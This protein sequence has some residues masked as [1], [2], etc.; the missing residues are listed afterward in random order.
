MAELPAGK[1][2]LAAALDSGLVALAAE[3]G[4]ATEYWDQGGV[5]HLVSQATV[6]A[7]LAALGVDATTAETVRQA[8]QDRGL[9]HWRR[10]MPPVF[11]VRQG[12]QSSCWVHVNHG[13]QVNVWV[14]LEASGVG[15]G[16]TQLDHVVAPRYVD[17]VLIGEAS[18]AVPPDLPTGWHTLHVEPEV[19]SPVQSPLVVTPRR[20]ALPARLQ[21]R[22]WGFA[23]QLYAV[24][25]S[26][27][28]GVGDL[29]D[30]LDLAAW[31]GHDL[32][33]DFI[34]V[35]PLHAASPMPPMTPSPYLPVTR[36]FVSP[37][38]IRVEA[39]PEHA[40]LPEIDRIHIDALGEG[41]RASS[42]A[43]GLIDRDPV[44]AAKSAAL[45][46]VHR[47]ALTPG[48]KADYQAFCER[49]GQGLEDFATWC[50]LAEEYGVD[51]PVELTDP[52]GSAVARE[53]GRLHQRVEFHRWCQWIVDEQLGAAQAT[54]LRAG[55]SLGVI[56]DLAVGVHPDGA[57][58]WALRSVLA[59][60]VSVGAPPDMYNQ[61][62]QDW[63]QPPWRPDALAEAG[64]LPY[65]DMLR[66]VLRHAG[67]IRVDHILGLFRLWWVPRGM[68]PQAGTYVRY[69]HEALVGI[70]A[71]EAERAGAVVIGEDLG[72]VESWVQDLLHDRGILGTSILWFEREPD[73]S[74]RPPERWR[75]DVLAAVTT[76]DLPPTAGY[77]AGEHVRLRHELGLLARPLATEE[78]EHQLEVIGWRA[79]LQ[80][81][82][83]LGQDAG[84]Q[85]VV[86]ALH[87]FVLRTP[88]RLVAVALPDAVGDRRAQNQP[89]TNLEYPNWRV[90]LT[91]ENGEVV[92]L[93]DLPVSARLLAL[94]RIVAGD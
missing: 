53:R 35:N 31:S 19:G 92:L 81:E 80:A 74:M 73:G 33:A 21:R 82:G 44:W 2:Q 29:M 38:Y 65:R 63:S 55:M 90:P 3:Y 85:E 58:A 48:R 60:D 30:L 59:K 87:R 34:L 24:R 69:D 9:Q 76:H 86:E 27:S 64:F 4:V 7:V 13:S 91:D 23:T 42:R 46:R 89:G 28:W 61:R 68:G 41:P 6:V 20:I 49:E 15:I 16:L 54:A 75:Q 67:G 18:F 36:R 56:H 47:V 78:S 32:G 94:A 25:S 62:G 22:A 79:Y 77:L 17:G 37:L 10:V 84:E 14:E 43:G 83:L 39:V 66:T 51:L 5:H 26:R 8:F 40:Y 12:D 11:V 1:P 71:L 50:A 57:D 93:E 72:T 88:A 52:H 70:L 45:Q